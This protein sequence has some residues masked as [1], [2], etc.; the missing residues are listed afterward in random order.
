M[1]VSEA[2]VELTKFAVYLRRK[3]TPTDDPQT[4]AN[5]DRLLEALATAI[6]CCCLIEQMEEQCRE[7]PN[8]M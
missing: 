5:S 3:Q 8:K 2:I 4:K 6:A 1:E 7:S